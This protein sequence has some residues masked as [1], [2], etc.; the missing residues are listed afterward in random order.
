MLLVFTPHHDNDN[1]S[2]WN[3]YTFINN[4]FEI[5]FPMNHSNGSGIACS[6]NSISGITIWHV[7]WY[8]SWDDN[9]KIPN[10]DQ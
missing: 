8:F 1:T 4:S 7:V 5:N 6:I 9:M 3:P 10:S 2:V